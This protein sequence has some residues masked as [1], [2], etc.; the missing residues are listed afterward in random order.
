MNIQVLEVAAALGASWLGPRAEA[1]DRGEVPLS[2]IFAQLAQARLGA[3]SIPARYG[4]LEA[5]SRLQREVTEELASWCGVTAFTHAQHQSACRIIAEA[6]D[7]TLRERQL[8]DLAAGRSW[9]AIA[10]AHLRRPGPPVLTAQP[11]PEGWRLNGTAPWVTGWGLMNQIVVA[12]ALPD[13]SH[14]WVW[15]PLDGLTATPPLQMCAMTASSTVQLTFD[16]WFVP[17]KHLLLHSDARRQRLQ[18][19]RNVLSGASLPLGCAAGAIRT[20]AETGRRRELKAA[21]DAAQ[22]L[23]RELDLLRAAVRG[24]AAAAPDSLRSTPLPPPRA[25]REAAPASLDAPPSPPGEDEGA[26]E[27]RVA[28][29]DLARRAAHAAVAAASGSANLLTHPAQ[30]LAREAMFYSVQAQTREILEATLALLTLK[31]AP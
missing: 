18:D 15:S 2:E 29:I 26:P 22:H 7:E 13:G 5:P 23:Q 11:G 12:A 24:H 28:A 31:E 19:R 27:T 16:N 17:R 4:G 25:A 3:L 10:F 8:P 21:Q 20:L 1:T 30:R 14:L 9:C 6:P